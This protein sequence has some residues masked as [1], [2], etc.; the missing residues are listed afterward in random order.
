LACSSFALAFTAK[1]IS[2]VM[3]ACMCG[4]S[5]QLQPE[6]G[7][8]EKKILSILTTTPLH[9]AHTAGAAGGTLATLWWCRVAG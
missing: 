7:G 6:Q 9:A 5:Q 2:A 1:L 4:K 8:F 3:W